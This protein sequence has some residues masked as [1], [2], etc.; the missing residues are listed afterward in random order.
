MKWLTVGS[1]FR[2]ERSEA[3][4]GPHELRNGTVEQLEVTS[5][6]K[7]FQEKK[8]H[9]QK[10]KTLNLESIQNFPAACDFQ[11]VFCPWH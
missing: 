2:R 7:C 9:I 6:V 1:K 4:K 8:I 10:I 3:T 5:G 11:A